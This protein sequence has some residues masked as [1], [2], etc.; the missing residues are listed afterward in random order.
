MPTYTRVLRGKVGA[1]V[2]HQIYLPVGD[3]KYHPLCISWSIDFV[4]DELQNYN[5]E[6]TSRIHIDIVLGQVTSTLSQEIRSTWCS[7]GCWCHS[8]SVKKCEEEGQNLHCFA[9]PLKIYFQKL[10]D[11]PCSD[12]GDFWALLVEILVFASPTSYMFTSSGFS[13]LN[14]VYSIDSSKIIGNFLAVLNFNR[15]F[16]KLYWFICNY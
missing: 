16:L 13:L 11:I 3:K 9:P 5:I 8:N 7:M 10:Q 4:E 1:F 6:Y 2:C 15:L 12:R 14:W